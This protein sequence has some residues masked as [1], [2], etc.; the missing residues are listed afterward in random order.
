MI[1]RNYV[2]LI[3]VHRGKIIKDAL[4]GSE[5]SLEIAELEICTHACTCTRHRKRCKIEE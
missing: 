3:S 4:F 5:G 1:K 2:L